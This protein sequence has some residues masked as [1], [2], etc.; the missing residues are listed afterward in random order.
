MSHE[1]IDVNAL[2]TVGQRIEVLMDTL[3]LLGWPQQLPPAYKR[4]WV[5]LHLGL[6]RALGMHSNET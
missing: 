4:D 5:Q 1:Q 6:Q 2:V 3:A